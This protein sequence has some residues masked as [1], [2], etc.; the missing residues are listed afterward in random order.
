MKRIDKKIALKRKE[1]IEMSNIL[2]K[3]VTTEGTVNKNSNGV[4]IPKQWLIYIAIA[5]AAVII[6][7]FA[8]SF[9]AQMQTG[10]IT[11]TTSSGSS[12]QPNTATDQIL[13]GTPT[14]SETA[15]PS[16]NSG[17]ETAVAVS[18]FYN[19]FGLNIY[20]DIGKT[21]IERVAAIN[22]IPQKFPLGSNTFLTN[23]KISPEKISGYIDNRDTSIHRLRLK[24]IFYPDGKIIDGKT[25]LLAVDG[26]QIDIYDVTPGEKR[27]FEKSPS[28]AG[29]HQGRKIFDGLKDTKFIAIGVELH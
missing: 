18:E 23:L 21:G 20:A 2:N 25:L 5:I 7:P 15:T 17:Q 10:I 24:I 12:P 4:F 13:V 9:V 26:D 27:F 3:S 28:G 1:K 8:L 14:P 29:S 19:K 6:S 16:Q 11:S 22:N